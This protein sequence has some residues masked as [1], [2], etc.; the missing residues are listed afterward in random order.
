MAR[1]RRLALERLMRYYRFLCELT[2]K[3]PVRTVTSA[4][5]AEAL[6]IDPT[7]VRKDFAAVGLQ[8]MGRVGFEVCE[9]CRAIRVSLGFDQRHEA[10]LIGAGHLGG[11][12]LAYSGFATYGLDIVAAFDSDKRKIGGK[13]AGCTVKPMRALKPFVKRREIRIA[14]LTT[15]VEVSQELADRLVSVGVKAI[16]NFTPNRV[17]VPPGVLVRN[18][19]ISVGLSQIAYHL[20]K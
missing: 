18:E 1:L 12:L 19:H 6:D 17:T 2:A 20:R 14:I 9:A 15:P 11:A 13:V 4:Q 7:Q 5:I 16:W 3:R 8:G 10:V